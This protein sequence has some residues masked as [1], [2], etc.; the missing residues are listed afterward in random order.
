M[1]ALSVPNINS[2]EA[3]FGRSVYGDA[4]KKVNAHVRVGDA[5]LADETP[6]FIKIDVEGFELQVLRGLRETLRRARPIVSL[7]IIG[8]HLKNA[9]TMPAD[10]AAE[11]K[12]AGYQGWRL[13]HAGHAGATHVALANPGSFEPDTWGDF[14]WLHHDDPLTGQIHDRLAR[15]TIARAQAGVR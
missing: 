10:I 14:L 2:G 6:R 4:V 3:T 11:M 9:G 5:E 15:M 1:L 8:Q 12:A 7:E 13:S